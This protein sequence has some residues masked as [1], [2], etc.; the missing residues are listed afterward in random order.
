[1]CRSF[2]RD[3]RA[4][5]TIDDE[6]G[7]MKVKQDTI[8][9]IDH[10]LLIGQFLGLSGSSGPFQVTCEMLVKCNPERPGHNVRV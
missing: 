6:T 8:K 2:A 5:A 3:V 4:G 10:F 9:T 7:E 1:M